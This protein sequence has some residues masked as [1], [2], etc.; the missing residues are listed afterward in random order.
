[1]PWYYYI[2]AIFIKYFYFLPFAMYGGYLLIKEAR[3]SKQYECYLLIIWALIFPLAFSFGRQ[4]LHY[5]ILPMYPA[6]SLLAGVAIDSIVKGKIKCK[7]VTALKYVLVIMSVAML[8]F[9]LRM[10]S[11]RFIET[12]R[13]APVI[14]QF[15][16][17]LP[18]YEFMVYNQDKAAILFYSQELTRVTGITDLATLETE[19]T[20]QSAKPKLCFMSDS[21]FLGLNAVTKQNCRIILSYK[22]KIVIINNKD[23]PFIVALPSS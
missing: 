4:K 20:S 13:M 5:F 19:L 2:Q 12:V 7:I 18:E 23:L 17:Q 6:T 15:L 21:D 11:K 8:S 10:E 22:G 1:M 3:K 14:D 16:R 9:P